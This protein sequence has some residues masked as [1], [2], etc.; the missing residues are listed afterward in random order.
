MAA[1]QRRLQVT[2]VRSPIG[3]PKD[4]KQTV[5]AMGLNRIGKT[6]TLP[7]NPSVRGMVRKVAHLIKWREMEHPINRAATSEAMTNA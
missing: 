1:S 2:L 3:C 7:D 4:Q 6:V 5:K